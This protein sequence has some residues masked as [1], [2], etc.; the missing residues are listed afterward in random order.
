MRAP[1]LSELEA[2]ASFALAFPDGKIEVA[3]LRFLGRGWDADVFALLERAP[4]GRGTGHQ[5]STPRFSVRF[6]R[7]AAAREAMAHE[8]ASLAELG[9]ALVGHMPV[10]I[11]VASAVLPATETFPEPRLVLVQTYLP[12]ETLVD[13]H[14]RGLPPWPLASWQRL[15]R[16]LGQALAALHAVAWAAPN[17]GLAALPLDPLGRLDVARRKEPARAHLRALVA[18]GRLSAAEGNVLDEIL[19]RPPATLPPGHAGGPQAV[20]LHA[21]L[22]GGNVLVAEGALGGVIDWVDL[23]RGAR[24]VD[25]AA[26]YEILPASTWPTFLDAYGPLG[27]SAPCQAW[28]RWRAVT[29][30]LVCVPPPP[31]PPPPDTVAAPSSPAFEAVVLAQLSEIVGDFVLHGGDPPGEKR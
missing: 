29:H 15:A 28:A 8:R 18:A 23:A 7:T 4:G 12:G 5:A 9:R 17:G 26:M 3:A 27:R 14:A 16:E 30:L 19:A 24:A 2:E 6:S 13:R 10:P 11:P 22:H 20:V 1:P 25:L 21:D 31:S